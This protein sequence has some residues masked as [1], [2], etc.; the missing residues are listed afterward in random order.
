MKSR[1]DFEQFNKGDQDAEYKEYL[2]I[3]FT[4]ASMQGLLSN[5]KM[6]I[7]IEFQSD[8]AKIS[9]QFA[10]AVIQELGL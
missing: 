1:Q 2:K 4:K 8:I 6:Q 5:S 3:E 9:K 7:T 10:E